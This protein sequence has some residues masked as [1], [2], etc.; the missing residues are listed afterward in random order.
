MICL[1]LLAAFA[2]FVIAAALCDAV[3]AARTWLLRIG[4]G[5]LP[6]QDARK[7][8]R[9]T[10]A[11]QLRKMPAVPVSDL[12]RFTLPERLQRIEAGLIQDALDRNNG[13]I[14]RTAAELGIKRQGLQ[15]KLKGRDSK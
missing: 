9:D 15:Y 4:I 5:T 14:S 6:P 1:I 8:M 2:A 12:T 3:P 10:A 7:K 11:R 13:N